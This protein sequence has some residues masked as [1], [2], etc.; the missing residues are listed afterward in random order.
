MVQIKVKSSPP[1]H[2]NSDCCRRYQRT[3]KW[4]ARKGLKAILNGGGAGEGQGQG[5]LSGD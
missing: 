5:V 2:L 4:Q 1:F 3:T